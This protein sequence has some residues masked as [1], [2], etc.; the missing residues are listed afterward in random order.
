MGVLPGLI[1]AA[2]AALPVIEESAKPLAAVPLAGPGFEIYSV[3]TIP[4]PSRPP[5]HAF[6]RLKARA[7]LAWVDGARMKP[8]EEGEFDLLNLN[9]RHPSRVTLP[10]L[11][12]DALFIETPRVF[13]TQYEISATGARLWVRNTLENTVNVYAA[14]SGAGA[15]ELE[16]SGTVPPGSTQLLILSG[17]AGISGPPWRIMLEKQ[18]EAMEGAYRFVKTVDRGTARSVNSYAKP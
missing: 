14:V 17:R 16:G 7:A 10:G 15:S 6:Y 1:G 5:E 3:V 12:K 9:P 4:V 18:E 11:V 8:N 2:L 13:V